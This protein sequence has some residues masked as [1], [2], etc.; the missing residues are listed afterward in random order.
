MCF[1]EC[2][3]IKDVLVYLWLMI[4]CNDDVVFEWVVN[5]FMCGIG[6]CILDEVCWLVCI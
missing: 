5:M 1:F 4:N 2:V 3:E 6:D